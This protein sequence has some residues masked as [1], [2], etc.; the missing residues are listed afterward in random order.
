MR[1]MKSFIFIEIFLLEILNEFLEVLIMFI[2]K[3][4]SCSSSN[5]NLLNEMSESVR[6]SQ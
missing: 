1:N 2:D 3:N 6:I 4:G 5:L